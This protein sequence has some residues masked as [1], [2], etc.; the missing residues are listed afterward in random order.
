VKSNRRPAATTPISR[1][2]GSSFPNR[3]DA[4]LCP[5]TIDFAAESA[6]AGMR[7][8]PLAMVWLTMPM[9]AGETPTIEA[10]V[11]ELPQRSVP[12][13]CATGDTADT[14]GAAAMISSAMSIESNL[15]ASMEPVPRLIVGATRIMLEPKPAISEEIRRSALVP[16]EIMV[17]T[18]AT[19]ITMPRAERMVRSRLAHKFLSAR[20]IVSS[21]PICI[22]SSAGFLY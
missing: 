17:I 5:R 8:L 19:P 15:L 1:P 14:A 16:T 7:L 13:I 3:S 11:V 2:I 21:S 18:E 4:I 20:P 6:S 9:Y 22:A 12:S 10:L